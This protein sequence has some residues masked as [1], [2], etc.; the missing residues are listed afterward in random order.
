MILFGL[1]QSNL[2]LVSLS[3]LFLGVLPVRNQFVMV[4][5]T[6]KENAAMRIL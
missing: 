1:M 3:G 5:I 6:W 2:I 4:F